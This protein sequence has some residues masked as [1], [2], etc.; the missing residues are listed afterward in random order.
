M[1]ILLPSWP[2]FSAFLLAS[3][4]LAITPGPG[5]LYIIGRSMAH[6]CRS[7]LISVAGIAL[8]NLGNAIAATMGLAALFALSALAFT[9]VKLAGAGYLVYLGVQMWRKSNAEPVL[10]DEIRPSTDHDRKVFRDGLVVALLN[11]KT[12]VFFAA[13][14]PQFMNPSSPPLLEGLLLGSIFVVIAAVTDSVYALAAGHIAPALKKV[15]RARGTGR[16]IGGGLLIGLGLF[17]A[18]SGSRASK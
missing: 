2:L 11:P 15:R 3:L 4:A 5:V 16:R 13:F 12:T 6:G 14:L 7:G 17:T 9:I 8:G 18:L 10:P 1:P